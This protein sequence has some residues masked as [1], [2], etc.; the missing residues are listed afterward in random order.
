[1]I[2]DGRLLI[3]FQGKDFGDKREIGDRY[4]SGFR[5]SPK[6]GDFHERKN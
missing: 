5:E 3:P 6:I 1:M 2:E 4:W